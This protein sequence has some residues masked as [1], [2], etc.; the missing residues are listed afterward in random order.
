MLVDDLVGR[1]HREPYRMFTSR[2]EHRLVL[3]V[4]SARERLM[5]RGVELGLVPREA[6]EREVETGR[7]AGRRSAAGSRRSA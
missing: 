3:G 7:G 5:A 6:A 4:D 1:D 2:A